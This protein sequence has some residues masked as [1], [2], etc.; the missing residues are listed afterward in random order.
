MESTYEFLVK[1]P[2]CSQPVVVPISDISVIK[3]SPHFPVSITHVHNDHAFT[4]FVDKELRIRAVEASDIIAELDSLKKQR[5]IKELYIPIPFP[6]PVKLDG[7]LREELILVS[8]S[9]GTRDISEIASVLNIS[10][11]KA[12]LLAE[13]LVREKKLLKVE[14]RINS[15]I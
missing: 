2:V 13:K 14:K 8:L 11:K 10:V 6:K 5:K 15:S 9:D 4:I 1:C 3:N 12:K 7:L